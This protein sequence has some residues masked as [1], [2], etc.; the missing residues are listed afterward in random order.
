[1]Y[2]ECS[3]T[4][5]LRLFPGADNVTTAQKYLVNM[6]GLEVRRLAKLPVER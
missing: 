1:V 4:N 3:K 6:T 5:L 2:Y